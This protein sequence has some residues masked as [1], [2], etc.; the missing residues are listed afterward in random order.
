VII[1]DSKTGAIRNRDNMG[2]KAAKG[3]NHSYRDVFVETEVYI[4]DVDVAPS[5]HMY[6]STR[7]LAHALKVE[8][9]FIKNH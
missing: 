7:R 8:D 3:W 4:W 6:H 5:A 9:K 1:H 2:R